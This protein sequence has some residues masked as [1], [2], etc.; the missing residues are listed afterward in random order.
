VIAR[1]AA[2][3]LLA[4]CNPDIASKDGAEVFAKICATCHGPDGRPTA[5]NV[6]RLGV[7]D[8]TAPEFRAR[9]TRLLVANQIKTGSQNKLMPS[10]AGALSDEQIDA[11][12]AYVA[13]PAFVK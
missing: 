5:A 1:Y 7:K 3:L 6:A 11:V 8:L 9:V 12:A 13:S 10:F 4:A 2:V